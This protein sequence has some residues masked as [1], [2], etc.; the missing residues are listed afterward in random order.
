[1]EREANRELI[2]ENGLVIWLQRPLFDLPTAGRPIS[3]L[4]SLA[5]IFERRRPVY[6]SWSDMQAESEASVLKT[7]HH[8]IKQ[9]GMM[10]LLEERIESRKRP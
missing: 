8:I 2:R 6:E 7:A 9:L 3:Q 5:D 10:D 4:D 1:M